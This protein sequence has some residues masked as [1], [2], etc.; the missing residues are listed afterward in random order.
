MTYFMYFMI[1]FITQ[2]GEP[3]GKPLPRGGL[4]SLR[5]D[6]AHPPGTWTQDDASV[7]MVPIFTIRFHDKK[8]EWKYRFP[9]ISFSN[10]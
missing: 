5:P 9:S 1:Y 2:A 7:N 6:D 3:E 4:T 8:N 10:K